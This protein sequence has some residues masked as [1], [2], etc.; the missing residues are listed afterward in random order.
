MH[1]CIA[2]KR[3]DNIRRRAAI[4]TDYYE[5]LALCLFDMAAMAAKADT[6][7]QALAR[8]IG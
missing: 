5:P 8:P 3:P 1:S 7:A 2:K 4:I 6:V